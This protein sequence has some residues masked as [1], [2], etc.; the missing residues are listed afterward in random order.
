MPKNWGIPLIITLSN[1]PIRSHTIANAD[2]A[3]ELLVDRRWD[4]FY[5][6]AYLGAKRELE[7]LKRGRG[8]V[9]TARA[10]FCKA[11][12]A[13]G[14]MVMEARYQQAVPVGA[15]LVG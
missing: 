2:E 14:H 7:E 10:A 3:L 15:G 8:S 1:D 6:S 9:Q 11:V 5:S 12:D 4:D 13:A